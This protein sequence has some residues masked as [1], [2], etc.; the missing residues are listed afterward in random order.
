MLLKEKTCRTIWSSLM[1]WPYT[2]Q[3]K[4]YCAICVRSCNV[5]FQIFRISITEFHCLLPSLNKCSEIWVN[6]MDH[7]LKLISQNKQ[8]IV[9]IKDANCLTWTSPALQFSTKLFNGTKSGRV[10]QNTWNN[11][12]PHLTIWKNYS[13]YTTVKKIPCSRSFRSKT[14]GNRAQNIH[15]H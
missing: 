1:H 15:L 7:H 11:K 2:Y 14:P 13:I 6:H 10:C 3:K 8:S 4:L 9:G 5:F 12:S